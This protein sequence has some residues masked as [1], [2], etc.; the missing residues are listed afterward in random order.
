MHEAPVTSDEKIVYR[1]FNLLRNKDLNNLLNLFADDAVIF[2]PFSKHGQVKG[3]SSMESFLKVVMMA[4]DTM[5]EDIVIE[6]KQQSNSKSTLTALVTFK[7]GDKLN[8]RFTFETVPD[9]NN[10]NR[11]IIKSLTIRFF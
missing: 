8:G 2:E 10:Q 4:T 7:L 9:R 5:H 3:K 1:Y 11:R 6:N